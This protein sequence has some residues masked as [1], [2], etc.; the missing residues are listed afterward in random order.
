MVVLVNGLFQEEAYFAPLA[1]GLL[2]AIVGMT[3]GATDRV[4]AARLR[5]AP[6]ALSDRMNS[7]VR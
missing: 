4:M 5:Q 7:C 1:L 2:M 3:L 6:S